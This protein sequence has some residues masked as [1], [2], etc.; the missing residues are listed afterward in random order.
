MERLKIYATEE[1]FIVYRILEEIAE[2]YELPLCVKPERKLSPE[3][4]L[5]LVPHLK[6]EERAFLSS[7]GERVKV[8]TTDCGKL[9]KCKG[10]KGD[11]VIE[12]LKGILEDYAPHLV[13]KLKRYRSPRW[14]GE[15]LSRLGKKL[16]FYLPLGVSDSG[17]VLDLWRYYLG[18]KGFPFSGYLS[19]FEEEAV[20]NT[21][22]NTAFSDKVFPLILGKVSEGFPE[23]VKLRG[24]VPFVVKSQSEEFLHRVL[25]HLFLV[26]EVVKELKRI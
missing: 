26:R 19:P 4:D 21:L 17:A 11:Y 16:R 1:G 7:A 22:T 9:P 18:R 10:V 14:D 24:F 13:D 8:V 2:I 15:M 5:I 3:V 20:L 6:G 12:A 23:G 25:D